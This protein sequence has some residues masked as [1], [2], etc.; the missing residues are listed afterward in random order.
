MRFAILNFET[1]QDIIAME[2]LEVAHRAGHWVILNNVHLMPRWLLELEKRLDEFAQEGSDEKFRLFLSSDP[3]KNIPI[4]ILARCIKIR[5]EPPTGLKPNLKRAWSSFSRESI[6]D[7]DQ[8]SKAIIFGLCYFH[9]VL[10]ERKK[11]G[12]KGF[13][14]MYPFSLGDLRDSSICLLNYMENAPSKIPWEDLKYIFGQI[15]YGGHIVNDWDRL[16][17]MTYLGTYL[18]Q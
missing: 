9:S 10:T 3:A 14:M 11:F 4:G 17:A 8:K 13:N 1:G 15:I 16:L 12:P 5:N 6:A 7:M 2:R 18:V